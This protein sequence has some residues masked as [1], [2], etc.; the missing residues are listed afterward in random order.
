MKLIKFITNYINNLIDMYLEIKNNIQEHYYNKEVI[1]FY[2]N[3][4]GYY[5][6]KGGEKNG[7]ESN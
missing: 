2:E 5:G 3:G 1:D 7:I 6:G 4:I